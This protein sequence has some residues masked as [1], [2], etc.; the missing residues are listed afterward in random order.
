MPSAGKFTTI[1]LDGHLGLRDVRSL[2]QRLLDAYNQ[3]D[4]VAL[5]VRGIEHVDASVIQLFIAARK[6]AA[7]LG[8]RL[9]LSSTSG[10][11]LETALSEIGLLGPGG[12]CRR[13][14]DQF[15]LGA[16]APA[17]GAK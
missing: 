6:K 13:E 14:D 3:F 10:G 2:Q 7:E 17:G 15:W 12:A 5:D 16:I 1:V 8:H 9:T 11:A 4:A